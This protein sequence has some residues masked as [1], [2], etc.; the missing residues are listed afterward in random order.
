M[1]NAIVTNSST[2]R[3]CDMRKVCVQNRNWKPEKKVK[4]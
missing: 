1:R 4:R 3:R 2:V